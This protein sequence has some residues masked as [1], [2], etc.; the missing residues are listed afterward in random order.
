MC[1]KFFDAFF[2][3]RYSIHLDTLS[4]EFI[5]KGTNLK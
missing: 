2:Y 4:T 5:N 3:R 1:R